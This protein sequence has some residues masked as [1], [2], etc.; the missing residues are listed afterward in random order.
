LSEFYEFSLGPVKPVIYFFYLGRLGVWVSKKDMQHIKICRHM[1]GGLWLNGSPSNAYG[2][3]KIYWIINNLAMHFPIV[4][5]W[6][7]MG[8]VIKAWETLGRAVSS[9]N[10]S[11]FV[12]FF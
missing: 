7:T 1:S 11:L 10:A 4:L 9:G 8:L 2:P 6:Y 5:N 12:T 3:S